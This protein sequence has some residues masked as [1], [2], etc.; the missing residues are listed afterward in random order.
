V[1]FDLTLYNS[2]SDNQ[3]YNLALDYSTGYSSYT[4]NLGEI[5]NKGVEVMVN[6]TP[7]RTTNFSWDIDY[8]FTKNNEKLVSLPKSLGEK[9]DLGGTQT[10]AFVA[11]VGE[12]LGLF[13]ITVPQ[14]TATGQTVVN[15]T[16]G[17][18]VAASQKAVIPKAAYDYTMGVT[19]TLR[20]KN[21]NFSFDFDIRQGGLIYSRTKDIAIFTGNLI[22]TAYNDRN[23]FVI[24]NSVVAIPDADGVMD[25]DGS[26]KEDY[27]ENSHQIDD[28]QIVTYWTNGGSELDRAFLLPRSYIK[29]KRIVLGYTIP[30]KFLGKLPVHDVALSVFAN[31]VFLWTP[32]DNHYIDPESSTFGNDLESR[33]GEFSVNPPTRTFGVNLRLVF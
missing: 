10:L 32:A 19:N 31:N 27:V 17:Q 21:I 26:G 30:S 2:V 8:N 25:A 3:I 18:P 5:S 6:L 24:P 12:P 15:A 14:V 13:E 4:T 20:Y 7:V 33:Y 29:L 9:I 11:K 28:S 1:G 16:T 22:E 23:P